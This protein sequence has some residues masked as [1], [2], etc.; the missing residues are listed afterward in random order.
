MFQEK[1]QSVYVCILCSMAQSLNVNGECGGDA[2][3]K[4]SVACYAKG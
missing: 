1:R 3:D 2:N 4:P